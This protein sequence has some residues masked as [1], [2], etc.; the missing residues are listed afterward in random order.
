MRQKWEV[1]GVEVGE[2]TLHSL[3]A[4]LKFIAPIWRTH[5]YVAIG[6]GAQQGTFDGTGNVGPIDLDDF[7][8]SRW[9]VT[10]RIGVG[11]D[12][13]IT[14]NWLVN[15]EVAPSIRFADYSNIPR[16]TTDNVTLTVSG[17]I[18]YRF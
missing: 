13:Y 18:Q 16:E 17:G 10:I 9:D 7:D 3:V 6:A 5:P 8:T 11:L 1:F 14:E 12:A 4:N 2:T 15:V